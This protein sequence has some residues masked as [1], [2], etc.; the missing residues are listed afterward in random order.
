MK[1]PVAIM[2]LC[3]AAAL[4]GCG[5]KPAAVVNGEKI[6]AETLDRYVQK[7][8]KARQEGGA[9]VDEAA[10][11]S[12][13]LEQMV[14]DALLLQGAKEAGVVVPEE[15]VNRQVDRIRQSMGD[16]AFQQ[17]LSAES[18]TLEDLSRLMRN[19][20][21]KEKFA[22]SLV[23][24]GDVAEDEMRALYKSDPA[25]FAV[26]ET[27][28]LRFIQVGSREEADGLINTLKAG[29]EGF[30]AMAERLRKEQKGRVSDYA[31]ASKGM[32]SPEMGQALG[33]IKAGSFGGP[34]AGKGGYFLFRVKDRK[35]GVQKSFE[36][37]RGEV[38]G[39]VLRQKRTE[40]LLKWVAEKK[41]SSDIKIH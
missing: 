36:E 13:V 38:R 24:E 12:A 4:A 39:A 31:W 15:E 33:T 29:K 6:S 30:D 25:A 27:I 40:A 14:V 32:F 28:Q 22:E 41:K 1:K 21:M 35:K 16:A 11:R 34:V 3:L 37:A 26:P 23:S 2:A 5:E 20:L 7:S 8:V 10:L 18:M 9:P 19:S 17:R